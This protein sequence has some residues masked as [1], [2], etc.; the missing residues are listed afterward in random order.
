MR[1][2]RVDEKRWKRVKLYFVQWIYKVGLTKP[3]IISFL[4]AAWFWQI[5]VSPRRIR[6]CWR[7]IHRHERSCPRVSF[8]IVGLNESSTCQSHAMQRLSAEV[9]VTGL[10]ATQSTEPWRWWDFYA[11]DQLTRRP[12][13]D[14]RKNIGNWS[15]WIYDSQWSDLV[16]VTVQQ[17]SRG[18]EWS[19]SLANRNG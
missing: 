1:R 14:D 12:K 4:R 2:R 6:S 10:P 16:T 5:W 3:N 15:L 17:F 9:K 19:C 18:I 8:R 13:R 11:G 7:S